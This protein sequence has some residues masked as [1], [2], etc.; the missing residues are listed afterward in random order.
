MARSARKVVVSV[1]EIV[2]AETVVASAERTKLFGFEVD[3]LVAAPL[4]AWP[5]SA[6][7]LYEEDGAWLRAHAAEAGARL[8]EQAQA[9]A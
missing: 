4:G 2:P 6:P 7:P 3:L 5:G 8:L 9:G 1:E